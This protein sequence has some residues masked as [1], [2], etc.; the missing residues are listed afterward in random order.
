MAAACEENEEGIR[1]Y[2]QRSI[3]SVAGSMAL[4]GGKYGEKRAALIN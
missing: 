2:Q 3:M 1:K 4:V